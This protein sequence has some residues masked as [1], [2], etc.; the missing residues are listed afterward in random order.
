MTDPTSLNP[1]FQL[2]ADI[3]A[4]REI[5]P[6]LYWLDLYAPVGFQS[7]TPERPDG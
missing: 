1:I 7:V 3:V 2:Q 6:G 5:G 4:N